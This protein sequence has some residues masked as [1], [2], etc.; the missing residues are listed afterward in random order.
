MQAFDR[1]VALVK[2]L[3]GAAAVFMCVSFVRQT[4]DSFRFIVPYVE[5]S[6]EMRGAR[7]LLLDTSVI[8]DGR[9]RD[10]AE[11]RIIES[12]VIVPR[13]VL[14]ELQTVADSADKLKRN[15]GRRGLD[16]LN[17]LRS[18]ERITIQIMDVG[19]E[20]VEGQTAVDAQLVALAKRLNGRV[21]TNDYNLNKIAELRGVDV[22]NINDLA[23]ALKPVMLP[24]ESMSVKVIR[25]GEEAGQGVGYLED[26][27]M[28]VVE[29]GRDY[30][31]RDV[32]IT[33]TSVLQTSAGRMIFG[34]AEAKPRG[35]GAM[36][37]AET[38]DSDQ[39]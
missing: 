28:I 24:G 10:I 17:R 7:P 14:D 35:N 37:A 16:I 27:T 4:R 12:N 5:F 6:R 36:A 1:T 38:S 20:D 29:G 32:Q 33:V 18:S 11:T 25:P 13:F 2:L 30:I 3:V 39:T 8:I 22:I 31:D 9:I 21:V 15:R 34:K 23:N 19:A 26:G